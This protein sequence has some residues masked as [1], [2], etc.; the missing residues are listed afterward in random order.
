MLIK[1]PLQLDYADPPVL[2]LWE[3]LWFVAEEAGDDDLGDVRS[4]GAT[5]THT[6]HSEERN[7]VG[8]LQS[9]LRWK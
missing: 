1:Q 8:G 6:H 2:V 7:K 4:M 5:A 3:N 9:Q